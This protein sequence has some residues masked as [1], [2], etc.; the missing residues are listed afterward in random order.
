MILPMQVLDFLTLAAAT[1]LQPARIRRPSIVAREVGQQRRDSDP[2][3]AL[4][5]PTIAE[6]VAAS[7]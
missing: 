1:R 5:A 3:V 7:P 4:D 2:F 6:S